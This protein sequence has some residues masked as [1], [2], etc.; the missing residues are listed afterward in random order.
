MPRRVIKKL[1]GEGLR[2]LNDML[3]EIFQKLVP[4]KA[5]GNIQFLPN[6][7]IKTLVGARVYRSAA[8][9]IQPT[10]NTKI[11]LD[12]EDYDL[13]GDFAS[14]KFTVPV[15]GYYYIQGSIAWSN[16][17]VLD[18][19]LATKLYKN[20]A[21][22]KDNW[23]HTSYTYPWGVVNGVSDIFYLAATD[24]I[25]LYAFIGSGAALNLV[26]GIEGTSL[27]VFLITVA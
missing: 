5:N 1:D 19:D 3:T 12:A 26:S 23:Q 15:S 25:E 20:G 16:P 21:V 17:D 11:L 2:N 8:Q 14:N 9:T 7:G 22:I 10:T 18:I 6:K 4:L 27:T 13:G 24:Y